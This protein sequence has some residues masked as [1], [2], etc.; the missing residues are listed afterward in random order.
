MYNDR[1][2]KSTYQTEDKEVKGKLI[3]DADKT[4]DEGTIHSV[5]EHINLIYVPHFFKAQKILANVNEASA[6]YKRLILEIKADIKRIENSIDSGNTDLQNSFIPSSD[7]RVKILREET[8]RQKKENNKLEAEITK[9][10]RDN[11]ELSNSICDTS[12]HI[13]ILEERVGRYKLRNIFAQKLEAQH[14]ASASKI[15][16]GAITF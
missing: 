8:T 12:I 6:D 14:K 9:T 2:I 3:F 16:E 10:R 15:G 5:I 11:L 13:D 4:N 1:L 7:S